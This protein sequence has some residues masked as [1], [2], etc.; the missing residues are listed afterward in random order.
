MPPITEPPATDPEAEAPQPRSSLGTAAARNLAT[1]TKSAPQMQG[2]TS[3]WVQRTLPW[4]NVAGGTYRVNRRLTLQVRRGRVGFTQ[5]GA[6]NVQIIPETLRA[7]PLLSGFADDEVLAELASRF[8]VR[9]FAPGE[10]IAEEGAPV[11]ET[12]VIA[13]GKLQQIGTGKYGNDTTL[14]TLSDGQQAGEEVAHQD[15]PLWLHTLRAVTSG[16]LMVLSSAAFRDMLDR[17]P[18]LREHIDRHLDDAQRPVDRHGQAK[19]A[20]AAGHDGEPELDSMFLDYELAPREYELSVAQAVLRL[21]TRVADLFNDPMNQFEQQLKL[22]IQELRECQESELVNN[23]EFGLLH[24]AS[25]D[26]RISTWSG[27]PTPDDM[28]DLLTMRRGTDAFFAHPKAIAALFRECNR[29][30]LNVDRTVVNGHE[31]VAWRGVPVYSCS[32]IPIQDGHMTSIIAVRTG[33]DNQGVVGLYQTGIPDEVEPGLNVRF[34]GIDAKS[35]MSYL[36]STYYSAAI[37]VPDA[38]GILENVELG[39]SRS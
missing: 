30:G 5:S 14:A 31:Q 27:P 22:T 6:D 2:I 32:K 24:N 8:W 7:I 19:A 17:F 12:Y 39:A 36:V 25:F 38:V 11:D 29:R 26:Q 4:V 3:R 9:E 21:H 1:T 10:V 35:V 37:L 20:I 23:R 34:M 15:D 13:H 28:D 18:Q 33:E 16:T